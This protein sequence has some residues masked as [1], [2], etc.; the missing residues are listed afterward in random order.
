MELVT[1]RI[2]IPPK[3]IPVFAGEADTRGAYGGRGS[4]KSRTFAKMT[5]IRAYMWS[6]EGRE[7]IILC[8]RQ[9]MNSLADSS[10]EE[11]KAAIQSEDWLADH[12][13]VGE[14]SVH[15]KDGRIA[16]TF[17]GLDRN[18]N[19]IK[20]KSR[21][22]LAWVDEAEPVT[23]E[24]WVKLIPTLR[25][26]G[27]ELWVT[28]NPERKKSATDKR[29]RHT[30]DTRQKV[31]EINWRDNPWF[32]DR[33]NRTR[34]KD[35]DERPD[36]YAHIW[37]GDYITAIEGAYYAK[38]LALAKEQGR[39]GF[40]AADPLMPIRAFFDIGGTG[41]KADATAIWIAQFIAGEIRVL[42]YYE[43][44]RQPLATHLNWLRK[45]GYTHETTTIWLPHDGE[46]GEK[47]I[48]ATY[49]SA[50]EA[51]GWSAIVVPNQGTGAAMMRVDA[52]RRLFPRMR[53]NK[54]TTEAGRDALGWYHEKIDEERNL[55]LGPEHDWSS[56]G[57]DAFGLMC[58]AYE[59]QPANRALPQINNDWVA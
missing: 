24:A 35:Q 32:P 52:G 49:R 39:I 6:S 50:I 27:S 22:L 48:D 40:F 8:G 25:E 59:E 51:A 1:A 56:H 19:S 20:S 21:I 34:I 54:D 12:F 55:G 18:I 5:A 4:G 13:E 2:E 16:Y 47:I 46:A 15:T 17:T 53:F 30:N 58:I 36:Q 7:G 28:W 10:L 11:V 3:L 9:F 43:A 38:A 23:D 42:D 31:V 29:F 37:E 14:K 57:A 33:L 45:R 44:V 41:R 26:E